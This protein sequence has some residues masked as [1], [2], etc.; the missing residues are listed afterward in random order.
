MLCQQL[1]YDHTQYAVPAEPSAWLSLDI[2][3]EQALMD[4]LVA[5]AGT[6][7]T[8]QI[9]PYATTRQFYQLVDSLRADYGFTLI[10][11]GFPPPWSFLLRAFV[12]TKPGFPALG[13]PLLPHAA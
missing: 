8:L 5:Y 10:F 12:V 6:N 11:P 3:P 13:A 2:L 4:Q 1:G 9:I 7:R